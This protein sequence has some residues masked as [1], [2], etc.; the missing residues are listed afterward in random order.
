MELFMR[1]TMLSELNQAAV[2]SIMYVSRVCVYVDTY[3]FVPTLMKKIK[4]GSFPLRGYFLIL[5]TIY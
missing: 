4:Q 3:T 5:T 1:I 2:N